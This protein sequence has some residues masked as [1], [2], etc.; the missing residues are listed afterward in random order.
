MRQEV[1]HDDNHGIY[2]PFM[3]HEH[4]IRLIVKALELLSMEDRR[5]IES[6]HGV[7]KIDAVRG[8]LSFPLL[9]G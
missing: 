6:M 2:H 5:K 8:K 3:L 9:R 4:E 7:G 1:I